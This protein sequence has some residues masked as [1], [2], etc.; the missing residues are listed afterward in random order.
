MA[1]TK[2]VISAVDQTKAAIASATSN[3]RSLGD[4]A[5]SL[6]MRFGS[7][8]VAIAG[9]FSAASLKQS[10]DV[11][12]RLD[13]LSEK[14]GIAVESLSALRYAGEVTGTPL[15]SIATSVKKLSVNMAEAASGNKEAA[16]IFG[17]LNIAVKNADGSLRGQDEVLLDL[18]D[19]FQGF[20]DGAGKAALAQKV[21]GK[22]GEEMIPLLN[23][24]AS[25]IASL[26][27]EAEALGLV[28]DQ[29]L[30]KEAAA[31]NDNLQ[32]TTLA[33]EA[34]KISIANDL[35]P[36]LRELTEQ[37]VVGRKNADGFW[38]ALVTFGP[39]GLFRSL[40]EELNL[41]N[42]E[43]DKIKRFKAEGGLRSTLVSEED[44][45]RLEKQKRYIQELQQA[46][47]LRSAA[48]MGDQSDFVS[49]RFG[50][51]STGKTEAPTVDRP[52][53]TYAAK[54]I[55]NLVSEYARLNGSLTKTDE[56]MRQLEQ[57]SDKFTEKQ[58]AE[59]L[60][61]AKLIDE[62]NQQ[63]EV[64]KSWIEYTKQ[65]EAATNASNDA[66][67]KNM[68]SLGDLSRDY[69]FQGKL[70]GKTAE[71]IERM[72]F[73]REIELKLLEMI[74]SVEQARENGVLTDK[75]AEER[76][77]ALQNSAQAALDA[78][79]KL[80]QAREANLRDPI[81]GMREGLIEYE[82]TAIRVGESSKNA[83][84]SALRGM[85]EAL[86]NFVMKG[87]LDF[88]SLANSIIS[89]LV[90]IRI[91]QTITAPFAKYLG[92]FLPSTGGAPVADSPTVYTARGGTFIN[93]SLS[94]YANTV[95]TKPTMFAFA[96][97]VGIMGEKIGSPGEAILP[98]SRLSNG[99]LGVK[100]GSAPITINVTNQA[101]GDGYEATATTIDNGTGMSIDILVAKA[102]K[103]DLRNNGQV[104][105]TLQQTFGLA[106]RAG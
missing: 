74:S 35:L 93:S 38:D 79:E 53:D 67:V 102:V 62:K 82:R 99:D 21:F 1:E 31:F 14:S 19:R 56:I 27:Q 29:R 98:L 83:M 90:R 88:S 76:I 37:F 63:N 39:L 34:A 28:Y 42:A 77:T 60:S 48:A 52:I 59:A 45:K 85:E 25:G 40:S 96:K 33:I 12:D 50:N 51:K 22:S 73:A 5:A 36:Y 9:A 13:D 44:L 3:L 2:I 95:V 80:M 10:I 26:R 100:S 78:Q 101:S 58:K 11:L 41:I 30:T 97:G 23:L 89:D 20:V 47:A 16:A 68:R 87:K 15:D 104:S 65:Q 81:D 66:F 49:R 106:R 57:A 92:S 75:E 8:G 70:I 103:N 64:S 18:A 54:F 24:G 43:I 105:Q 6:P 84:Q 72:N 46:E 71:Q 86:V 69:E 91:Q 32:K 17:T 94:D 7:I 4:M 55:N 61:L